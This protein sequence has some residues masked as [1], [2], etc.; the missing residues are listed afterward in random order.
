[1]RLF[2]RDQ[3]QHARGDLQTQAFPRVTAA[4]ARL[5]LTAKRSALSLWRREYTHKRSRINTHN[6]CESEV[7]VVFVRGFEAG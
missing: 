5:L 4:I 3:Q 2:A 7:K 6:L 1:M